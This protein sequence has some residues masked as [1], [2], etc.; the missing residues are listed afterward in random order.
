M[1]E[2]DLRDLVQKIGGAIEGTRSRN[3]SRHEAEQAYRRMLEGAGSD[4]QV[5]AI[6]VAMRSRGMTGDE[7]AGFATAARARVAFPALPEGAVVVSTSRL[8]KSRHPLLALASAAAAAACGVPVLVQAAPHAEGAGV[9]VGDLWQRLGGEL[10][11]DPDRAADCLRRQQ[12]GFWRPTGADPGWARLLEVENDTGLRSAPDTVAKL[13]APDGCRLLVPARSGPVLG[14]A[15]EALTSLG[16]ANALIVQGVEGSLDPWV[17]D[18]T[19]GLCIDDGVRTPLRLHPADLVLECASEPGQM[20]E[21]R[22][23]ASVVATQQALMGVPGPAY[24]SALIG[25]ALILRLAGL[26]PDFATAVGAAREVFESGAAQ[27]RLRELG[28]C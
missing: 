5:A 25:A 4:A 3:L 8:G 13:L 12:L 21:D 24:H 9:T 7:L 1:A 6:F 11:A 19:R 26:A 16:H 28:G 17:S 14:Q 23:E 18:Q 15:S 2:D 22:L 10:H 27:H 20:H